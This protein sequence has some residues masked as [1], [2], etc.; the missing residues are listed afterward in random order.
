MQ[1]IME[2]LR[3]EFD[4]VIYDTPPLLGLADSSLLATYTNGIVLVVQMDKTD[5]SVLMQALDQLKFSRANIL[6]IVGNGAKTYKYTPHSYYCWQP[7]TR[8]AGLS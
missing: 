8:T 1:N 2:Q 6:G 7:Y 4:L 5:R 3:Q